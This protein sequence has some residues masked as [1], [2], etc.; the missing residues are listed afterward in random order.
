MLCGNSNMIYTYLLLV[1]N[2]RVSSWSHRTISVRGLPTSHWSGMSASGQRTFTLHTCAVPRT[3]TSLG[4]RSFAVAGPRLWNN[5]PVELRQR[6]IC[7][8]K[9]RRL[10]KTFLFCWDSAPCDFLFKC[11]VYKYTYLLTYL[12]T[13]LFTESARPL[14]CVRLGNLCDCLLAFRY[15][16]CIWTDRYRQDIYNGRCPNCTRTARHYSKFLC[17]HIWRNCQV[18]RRRSVW[19][20]I[21][22]NMWN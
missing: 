16:L 4:D 21:M 19:I 6:D 15:N 20:W 14:Q 9:F 1:Y 5:L 18:R 10:L 8:S 3:Q 22:S 12:L 11:A 17:P 13:F 7:L 2:L